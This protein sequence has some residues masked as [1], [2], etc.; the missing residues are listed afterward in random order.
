[1][2]SASGLQMLPVLWRD[3]STHAP[4]IA[5]ELTRTINV[6]RGYSMMS[7][8]RKSPTRPTSCL[9]HKCA[10]ILAT[11]SQRRI[12]EVELLWLLYLLVQVLSFAKGVGCETV[13]PSLTKLGQTRCF[14]WLRCVKLGQTNTQPPRATNLD[15]TTARFPTG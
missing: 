10:E 7:F 6:F 9:A 3:A 2:L 12:I 8:S 4:A 13:T 15:H 1:M 5:D 11:S 14:V